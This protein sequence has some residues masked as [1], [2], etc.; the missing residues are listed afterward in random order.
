[1]DLSVRRDLDNS[2]HGG[3]YGE[4]EVAAVERDQ[5]LHF[6]PCHFPVTR[7]GWT[8]ATPRMSADPASVTWILTVGATSV[9]IAVHLYSQGACSKFNPPCKSRVGLL[10]R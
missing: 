4:G 3:N 9:T 8:P 2:A 7:S 1:M 10:E 5:D 6:E